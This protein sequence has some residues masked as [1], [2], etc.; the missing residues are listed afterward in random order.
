VPISERWATIVTVPSGSIETK[1]CGSVTM[2]F[3]MSRP[4]VGYCSK[5]PA[6]LNGTS[7][8]A[9]TRPTPEAVPLRK[10]RRLTFS[11]KAR[12]ATTLGARASCWLR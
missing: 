7:C 4:P 10:A 12:S 2:P 3:G 8:M 6:P 9:T 5:A 1:T 11:M